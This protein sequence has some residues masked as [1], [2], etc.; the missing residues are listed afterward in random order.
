MTDNNP[1]Q[2][3]L[4]QRDLENDKF[5]RELDSALAKYAAVEP[6]AGL[7][8]RILANLRIEQN[9][10]AKRSWWRWPV[11]AAL[12]ALIV[13]AVSVGWRSWRPAQNIARRRPP[14]TT[15]ANGNDGTQPANN[16]GIRSI[17]SRESG[18][19]RRLKPRALSG[20]ATIVVPAPK[21]ERFPSPQPLSEQETILTR[22]V[23]N[24]PEHAALIAQARGD[25]LRR[26]SAEEMNEAVS[27]SSENSQPQNKY[28]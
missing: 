4:N 3:N 26:D 25:E 28:K 11:V 24:Y 23:A 21:L 8:D 6:R 14:A 5:D 15:Q 20:P 7:E 13:V 2:D 9:L 10:A 17:R 22:Y 1:R 27:S 18:P 16:G 19:G 12:A